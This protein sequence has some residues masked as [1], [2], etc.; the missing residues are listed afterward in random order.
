VLPRKFAAIRDF[1]YG[2]ALM[3]WPGLDR[4]FTITFH[5]VVDLP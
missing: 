4:C 1:L 2:Q 3:T 5:C